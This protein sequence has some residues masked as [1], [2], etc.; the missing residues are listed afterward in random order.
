MNGSPFVYASSGAANRSRYTFVAGGASAGGARPNASMS[1]YW[2]SCFRR[3]NTPDP[4]RFGLQ[5]L[6]NER[7]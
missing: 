2:E 7:Q 1:S 5:N 4:A 3:A 6:I